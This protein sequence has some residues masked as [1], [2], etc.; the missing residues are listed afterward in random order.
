[1]V[2]AALTLAATLL[3]TCVLLISLFQLLLIATQKY[4]GGTSAIAHFLIFLPSE[5]DERGRRILRRFAFSLCTTVIFIVI[6]V[7]VWK[8]VGLE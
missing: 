6:M 3:S 4:T 7:L 5:H 2:L 1:M 8:D